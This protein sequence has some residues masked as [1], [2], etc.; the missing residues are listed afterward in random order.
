MRGCEKNISGF[1][2]LCLLAL[3]SACERDSAVLQ[4]ASLPA[5]EPDRFARFVDEQQSLP[6]GTYRV[7]ATT[8]N[9]FAGQAG[10]YTLTITLDDGSATTI[11]GGWSSSPGVSFSL[12]SYDSAN[13]HTFTLDVAGGVNVRMQSQ[14]D[15]FFFIVDA[16]DNFISNTG[17]ITSSSETLDIPW[18]RES[19]P[20]NTL[21]EIDLPANVSESLY[22]AQ[23]YYRAID[24]TDTRDR[25]SKWR[26]AN[27]FSNDPATDYDADARVLFRD[28]RDLG[29]GR[30]MYWKF[31]CDG[32]GNAGAEPGA[33]AVFVENFDVELLPGFPYSRLN[34]EAALDNQ[35]EYHFGT[36]AIEFNSWVAGNAG[37]SAANPNGRQFAKFYTFR[38]EST[39]VNA[40]Q[41]RLLKVDLDGRGDKA[42]PMPCIYCHGG[43]GLALDERGEFYAHPQTAIKGGTNAKLQTLDVD[44]FEFADSGPFTRSAQEAL[45]KQLNLAVYCTYP[46]ATPAAVCADL[47]GTA[48]SPPT[49]ATGEWAADFMREL[50]QGWYGG[51]ATDDSFPADR[52]DADAFVPVGWDPNDPSNASNPADIDVLYRDVI[53]PGCLVCHARRGNNVNSDIDFSSYNKL[54]SYLEQLEDYVYTRGIM[55][56]SLIGF[57]LFWE[58][59]Q[60]AT[61]ARFLDPTSGHLDAE[62]NVIRP[63]RPRAVLGPDRIVNVPATLSGEGSQF[64]QDYRW[65][66]IGSVDGSSPSLSVT[67]K[68]RTV[69]NTDLDGVYTVQLTVTQGGQSSTDSLQITVDSQLKPA[70]SIDFGDIQAIIGTDPVND[71]G[72]Q[73]CLGCHSDSDPALPGIQGGIG[74]PV[75]W[76]GSDGTQ[77]YKAI[78][79]RVNFA[80]PHDSLFLRKPLGQHHGGGEVYTLTDPNDFGD[81]HTVLSWITEGARP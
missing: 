55:P 60:A 47:F 33:V 58:S 80:A 64:A 78:L 17:F 63:G 2:M 19:A 18:I 45:L 74:V 54:T 48:F 39:A 15:P 79:Q 51:D 31:G 8:M 20:G 61:L 52:F 36:N 26:T 6:A 11:E 34:L 62:G 67:D 76:D 9:T 35:R 42:M 30:N 77:P 16:G 57:D 29:Y 21:V 53:L 38:P 22:Y 72:T 3:I 5:S 24:P 13:I 44:S 23:A 49:P 65:E 4:T 69:F 59:G 14:N 41:Q 46:D 75:T 73:G 43:R 40:D 66:I 37:V 32:N 70:V 68:P 81:Y 71:P 28:T 27:C 50:V 12:P 25:L 1:A 7:I 10:A 56:L